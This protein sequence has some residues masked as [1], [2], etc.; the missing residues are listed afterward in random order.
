MIKRTF[1]IVIAF[2]ITII[3]MTT[4]LM[5][6][7]FYN[8]F[9]TQVET[10]LKSV[11]AVLQSQIQ[12]GYDAD[13]IN[14]SNYSD[15]RI[16][17]IDSNGTVLADNKEDFSSLDNHGGRT[18]IEEAKK[19]GQA[20]SVR[21]SD[22]LGEKAYY[23]ATVFENG[24][25]LRVSVEVRSVW[26]ILSDVGP[27]ILMVVAVVIVFAVAVSVGI[28]KK[29][30]KPVEKLSRHLDNPDEVKA[31]P[32]LQPF[33]NA[34]KEQK[35]KQKALD[36]Q[37]KQFTANVSHELKT[38]LTS[39]A[40]YAELIETGIAQEA[41]VK[42]FA[43]IIRK[44]ALRLVSLSEDIIQLSQLDESDRESVT[45]SSVDLYDTAN[46]CVEALSI[47]ARLKN[48]TI[49]LNG[50]S[51]FVRANAP[52]LEELVYNLCDNAIRYNKENGRVDVKIEKLEKGAVLTVK[53]TGIG[54]EDKYKD[55]VFERFF[56][57]DKSRSKATGGT[58]LG[59]AIVKHI[60]E[61]HGA[62]IKV[63]SVLGEG[64]AI[65]VTFLK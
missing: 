64:T 28:T 30:I 9:E 18:E 40:G 3:V 53:D 55:R 61:I 49:S 44:Q 63:D 41:D 56:R 23:Y 7:V 36:K 6:S 34:L 19:S 46:K 17:L 57:V 38:P 11:S 14:A 10:E 24:E 27:Y 25:I 62:D 8:Y 32:E 59:L 51:T 42:P 54:I 35:E 12:N 5:S 4:A 26:S 45:F 20:F 15:I 22:T 2:G 47:N 13:F 65:S 29:I 60:A 43:G 58:G 50:E 37:K 33:V 1:S 52:L 48:I 21:E 31:Y 39:I 16:T